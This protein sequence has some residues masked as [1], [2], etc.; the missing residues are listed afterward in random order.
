MIARLWRTG[1]A[2]GGDQQYDEFARERSQPMFSQ[3]PGC[4]G[5]VFLRGADGERVVLTLWDNQ[6]SV[7]D[8]ASS[9]LYQDTARDL[10]DSGC[11]GED[12]SVELLETDAEGSAPMLF[13]HTQSP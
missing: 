9:V 1:L 12:Q 6:E 2:P 11:L 10:V 3:L 5:V 13:S 7:A 4:L 8:L